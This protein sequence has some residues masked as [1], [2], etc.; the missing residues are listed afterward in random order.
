MTVKWNR[1]DHN[2]HDSK[3]CSIFKNS[4]LKIGKPVP[5]P[6]FNIHNS[7][8]LQLVIRLTLRL[9][10]LNEHMFNHNF[11][12]HINPLCYCSLEVESVHFSYTAI[13]L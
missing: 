12:D 8:R 6:T 9:S 4:L 10:H 11:E 5:Q 1:L 2:L 3:S 13:I 7:L